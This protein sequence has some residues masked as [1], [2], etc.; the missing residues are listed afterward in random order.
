MWKYK[1]FN[2]PV[3]IIIT[4]LFA[5]AFILGII[6]SGNAKET[7]ENSIII[8]TSA[9]TKTE[10][11]TEEET[12]TET[13]TTEAS[14]EETTI[15]ETT[16]YVESEEEFKAT[17]QEIGYKTLLRNPDDYIGQRIII[18]A[19]IQ[20]IMQG[21]IFDS[22]Q[23][24]RLLTDNDGYEFYLDDEY[25]MYDYRTSDTTKLLNDDIIRVYA[26]F[27]GLQEIKRALTGTKEEIPAIKAYYVD[28]I[29]E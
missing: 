2:K 8:T 22:N 1:K 29:S 13:T 21:G 28:L 11:K 24:Y 3:R 4:V 9:P 19:K 27:S 16:V 26:E 14:V 17:C 6:G 15:E 25:F 12:T 18:T 10:L 23:Y 7:I 5:L 20:Q